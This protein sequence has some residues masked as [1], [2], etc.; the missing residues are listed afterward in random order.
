MSQIKIRI[1][2][3]DTDAG[4]IVYHANYLKYMERGRT[5]WLRDLGVDQDQLKENG[6]V[7]V[8]SEA[9]IKFH[10]PA[11]FNQ[12]LT[13]S[14]QVAKL[15]KVSILF[16]QQIYDQNDVLIAS[17]EVVIAS[18]DSNTMKLKAIPAQVK[19]VILRAL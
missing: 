15:R 12:L 19:E 10:Q 11:R 2:Y 5:E 1:Y 13:V 8:A 14:T 7:F 4:G 9:A 6:L 3:E 16:E 17:S 18:V